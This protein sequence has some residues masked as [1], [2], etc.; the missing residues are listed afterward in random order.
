MASGAHPSYRRIAQ[1]KYQ[2]RRMKQRE[3][4]GSGEAWR[5]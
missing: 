1:R 5:Q 2:R 4:I 3:N